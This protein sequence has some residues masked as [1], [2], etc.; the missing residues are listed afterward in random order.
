MS[1]VL[2]VSMFV[3]GRYENETSLKAMCKYTETR[4]LHY[5]LCASYTLLSHFF[6][7]SV[8]IFVFFFGPSIRNR[9]VKA[10]KSQ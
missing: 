5:A 7:L 4:S 3:Q 10:Y 6:L 1:I 2:V 9:M 8:V